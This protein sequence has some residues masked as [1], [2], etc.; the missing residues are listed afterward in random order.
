VFDPLGH[1]HQFMPSE[2]SLSNFRWLVSAEAA[3]WLELAGANL[4]PSVAAVARWRKELSA[5]RVHLVLQQAMLR[6]R[7]REKF[8]VAERLFFTPIGLEQA[9]DEVIARYKAERFAMRIGRRS[10]G[11]LV[12]D[13]C[14]GIGGDLMALAMRG[15]AIGVDRDPATALL[16]EANL[17]E[18]NLAAGQLIAMMASAGG[19]SVCAA[20]AGEAAE[21]ETAVQTADVATFRVAE[22]AAWHIDPD[23]RP[24]GRRTTR[25]VLHDPPPAVIERLLAECPHGAVK[26]APAAVLPDG[27]QSRA[28][29]QWISSRRECRQLVAWF[30]DLAESPG[31]RRATVLSASREP[32]TVAG[33]A[34]VHVPVAGRI[35]RYVFEPDAAVLAAGLAGAMAAECG[36][37]AVTASAAYLTGEPAS[38]VLHH[39]AMA[40]FE[41]LDVCPLRIKPLRQLLRDRGIGRVEVK[42]RGVDVD[43]QRL[44][45]E[46]QGPG[47]AR[48]A[49]LLFRKREKMTAIIARRL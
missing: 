14:C 45:A 11:G 33:E 42:K 21:S 1:A 47:E 10:F 24:Q 2:G 20:S 36:L 31:T 37:E 35:G 9:T 48:A 28:E 6:H 49:L 40:C 39:A 17:T 43:P 4:A 41:V 29:L 46:L 8:S 44:A 19:A 26:L 25:A 16:A 34:D 7:A 27:W 18:A 5:E 15:P 13:L 12:A 32:C 38:S 22:C 3:P 23:R 30:G